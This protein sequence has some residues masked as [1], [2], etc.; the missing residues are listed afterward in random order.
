MSVLKNKNSV[1]AADPF[2]S[3]NCDVKASISK[4]VDLNTLN[5]QY[6]EYDKENL[7]FISRS[8]EFGFS[9]S[10]KG[11]VL[12]FPKNIQSGTY[13]PADPSFPLLQLYYFE[14][15]ASTSSTT[16]FEYNATTGTV[17]VEVISNTPNELR[18]HIDFDFNGKDDRTEELH[19]KGTARLNVFKRDF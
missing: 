14:T 19:I 17:K 15:G 6:L 3:V 12:N 2:I 10:K 7:V 16:Y 18:Y 1:S 13:D 4:R 11:M 5:T 8:Y 9:D